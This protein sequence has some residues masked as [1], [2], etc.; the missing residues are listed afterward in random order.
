MIRINGAKLALEVAN[1]YPSRG[2]LQR[3]L[4]GIAVA[5]ESQWKILAKRKLKST[6]QAYIN[7]ISRESGSGVE[8]I[9]LSGMLP[10][11]VE[12][13][14]SGGDMLAGLLKGPKARQGAN[15]PYTTVPFRHG[16][17]GTSGINLGPTMP[18]SVHAAAKKL[19]PTLAKPGGGV[20]W[21]ERLA[22]HVGVGSAMHK[23]LHKGHH[24]SKSPWAGMIRK[25]QNT[26]RG[27]QT[28][29]YLTF[30][31]V[32]LKSDASAWVHPGITARNLH[33]EVISYV[34]KIA[35]KLV[36]A[37]ASEGSNR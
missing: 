30:R 22:G 26:K 20:A 21:G 14:W 10:N 34:N 13:G 2:D 32:S 9:V 16:T 15:G 33:K 36:A 24:R 25:G 7:G 17:P 27:V 18:A 1:K 3:A 28:S 23:M 6:A 5:A 37:A 4:Q 29:G 11:M 12:K 35:A 19:A 8:K 31:R